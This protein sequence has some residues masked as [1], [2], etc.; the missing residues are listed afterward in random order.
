M[1][2]DKITYGIRSYRPYGKCTIVQKLNGFDVNEYD[3]YDR[4]THFVLFPRRRIIPSRVPLC[5]HEV[6]DRDV[7]REY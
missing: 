3:G 5:K 2:G 7:K 4:K 1:E 6:D